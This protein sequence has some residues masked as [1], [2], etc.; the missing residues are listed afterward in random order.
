MKKYRGKRRDF[1]FMLSEIRAYVF[2]LNK[3]CGYR[4]CL[5]AKAES[6]RTHF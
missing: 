1:R 6:M 3:I 2:K 5:V 4:N